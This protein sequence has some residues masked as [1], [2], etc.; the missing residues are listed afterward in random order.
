M[1][2]TQKIAR[3]FKFGF[4]QT[5][6]KPPY[7]HIVQLGDPV[8]RCKCV[9]VERS[10]LQS[11]EFKK[12][13][14]LNNFTFLFTIGLLLIDMKVLAWARRLMSWPCVPR[15]LWFESQLELWDYFLEN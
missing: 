14:R 8:L 11:P 2:I 7:K 13:C 5:V 1:E 4:T 10:Y 15:V 3:L 6:L 9:P 12:V